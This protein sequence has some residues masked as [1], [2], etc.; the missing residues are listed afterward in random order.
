M[1]NVADITYS[2]YPGT[3][4]RLFRCVTMSATISTAACAQRHRDAQTVGDE[5]PGR[6]LPCRGCSIGAA[7]AG[8]RL[9]HYSWNYGT[10]ICPRCGRGTT[11]MI[12]HRVC[13][14]CY[15]RAR[16]FLSG[17]NA[18][19]RAPMFLRSVFPI[20]LH[21]T[22]DDKP[23]RIRLKRATGCVEV[24]LHILRTTPGQIS[25]HWHATPQAGDRP[26]E[27]A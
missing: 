17:K 16:E 5:D 13:V 12:G 19:G 1:N 21:Y 20:N 7:H 4:L 14:S 10:E 18:K 26:R 9:I 25:F 15:N 2:T 8:V 6:L 3:D 23:A 22:V 11:R 24:M 27:A